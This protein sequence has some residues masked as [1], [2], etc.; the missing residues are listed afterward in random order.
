MIKYYEI[1]ETKFDELIELRGWDNTVIQHI[2][3]FENGYGAS[4]I[5]NGFSYGLEL[6]V[7]RFKPSGD[8]VNCYNTPIADDVIGYINGVEELEEILERIKEL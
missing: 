2:Y 3:E 4:V 8:F 6:S 1:P 5:H 7:L